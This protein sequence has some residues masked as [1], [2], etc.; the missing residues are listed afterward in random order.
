MHSID[1]AE[2]GITERT[3]IYLRE[4]G[5]VN[6][7]LLNQNLIIDYHTLK[8]IKRKTINRIKKKLKKKIRK[9][10]KIIRKLLFPKILKPA[11]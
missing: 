3:I 5:L 6:E 10:I 7:Y 9:Q 11:L 2:H 1:I 4:E 8:F